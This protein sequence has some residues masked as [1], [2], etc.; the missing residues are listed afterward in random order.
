MPWYKD[1]GMGNKKTKFTAVESMRQ[2][3]EKI[4]LTDGDEMD[5]CCQSK[6]VQHPPNGVDFS[7]SEDI[8]IC[9]SNAPYTLK[10]STVQ[11]STVPLKYSTVQ[12]STIK[13]QYSTVQYRYST[14]QFSTVQI[15]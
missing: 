8:Y 11:Y 10:Y 6:P 9:I 12:Y 4:N 14:V 15:I 3:I 2:N 7:N 5:G 1:W 13:V